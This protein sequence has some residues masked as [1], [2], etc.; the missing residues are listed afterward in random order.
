MASRRGLALGRDGRARARS[1]A[2]CC[3]RRRLDSTSH[4]QFHNPHRPR[5]VER[6]RSLRSVVSSLRIGNGPCCGAAARSRSTSA[7]GRPVV[8]DNNSFGECWK[9]LTPHPASCCTS[10]PSPD[11]CRSNMLLQDRRPSLQRLSRRLHGTAG[12]WHSLI[13]RR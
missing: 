11:C 1:T 6:S 9:R 3:R 5:R 12:A 8:V 2:R 4:G 7:H 13:G 10:P